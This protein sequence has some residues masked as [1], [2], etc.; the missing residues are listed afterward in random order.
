MSKILKKNTHIF[1]CVY[2]FKSMEFERFISRKKGKYQN[3]FDY[4]IYKH[5]AYFNPEFNFNLN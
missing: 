2:E 4:L 3:P 1:I 5:H